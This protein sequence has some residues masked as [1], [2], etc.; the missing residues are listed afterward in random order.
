MPTL[1]GSLFHVEIPEQY[2]TSY[3][4]ELFNK[5]DYSRAFLNKT[6]KPKHVTLIYL[7]REKLLYL[8][9][10]NFQTNSGLDFD[11]RNKSQL[12]EFVSGLYSLK[13]RI[14]DLPLLS[15]DNQDTLSCQLW[16]FDVNFDFMERATAW[17]SKYAE[18]TRLNCKPEW[19]DLIDY[20][21]EE[22][23]VKTDRRVKSYQAGNILL[24][25]PVFDSKS[26]SFP[27]YIKKITSYFEI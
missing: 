17:V 14:R 24:Q 20:E 8:T 7:D 11:I 22:Y 2:H 10:D 9:E 19:K 4:I 13:A 27:I 23:E 12:R 6:E 3:S 25:Y 1:S 16:N 5:V 18:Y 15:F 21:E 26:S